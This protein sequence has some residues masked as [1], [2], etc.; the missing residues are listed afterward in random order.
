MKNDLSAQHLAQEVNVTLPLGV[1]LRISELPPAIA[2]RAPL[3]NLQKDCPAVG[4]KGL[5]GIYAGVARADEAAR[6]HLLEV[7]EVSTEPMT[8]AEAEKWAKEKGGTQPTRRHLSL[9][10]ANVPELFGTDA[11]WSCEQSA[12]GAEFAWA[13]Y[14]SYGTQFSSHK[15]AK[16]RAVAVRRLPIE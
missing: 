4:D 11:F 14:F 3:D 5:F 12:G 15:S 16:L 7:I 10:R 9:L 13:Q 1:L 2:V 8:W 6:D